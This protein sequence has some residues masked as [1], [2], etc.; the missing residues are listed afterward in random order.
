MCA[1]DTPVAAID[2]LIA[3]IRKLCEVFA[4]TGKASS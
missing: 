1:W 4:T 3:D 2:A